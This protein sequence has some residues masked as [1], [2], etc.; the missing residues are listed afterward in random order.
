MSEL[1]SMGEHGE[2]LDVPALRHEWDRQKLYWVVPTGA[3]LTLHGLI[4]AAQ[5]NAASPEALRECLTKMAEVINEVWPVGE[6]R[7]V[8]A[9]KYGNATIH[10]PKSSGL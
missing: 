5:H 6:P 4:Y 10:I 8:E 2:R 1:S 7:D 3:A 9:V